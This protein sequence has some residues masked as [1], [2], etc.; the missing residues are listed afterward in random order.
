M[1]TSTGFRAEGMAGAEH[2]FTVISGWGLISAR[3]KVVQ[4]TFL[5]QPTHHPRQDLRTGPGLGGVVGGVE[6]PPYAPGR[7]G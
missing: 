2:G 4:E 3:G 1:A 5:F 7:Y 6:M